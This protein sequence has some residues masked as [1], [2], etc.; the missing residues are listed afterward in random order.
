MGKKENLLK[1]VTEFYE[2]E[3]FDGVLQSVPENLPKRIE[4][5]E[6]IFWRGM[7]YSRL[8]EIK[9][10]A[11]YTVK[12][13]A[14]FSTIIDLDQENFLAVYNRGMIYYKLQNYSEAI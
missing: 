3:D 8:Y 5:A 14:D 2:K 6:L 4:N 11:D 13:I 7:A 9:S 12:A 10:V 1:K